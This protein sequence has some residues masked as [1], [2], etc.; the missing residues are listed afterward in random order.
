MGAMAGGAFG[1]VIH[2]L[3]P[4]ITASSGAYAL[5]GMGAVVAG[6][7]HAPIQAFLILFELTQDYL[8]IP[9]LMISCVIA[10]IVA[11][12]IKKESIY[13]LKLL[14]RG[15]DI[16]AGREVNILKNLKVKDFMT[17]KPETVKESAPLRELIT[18]LPYSQHTSFPVVDDNGD[19]VGMLSLKDFRELVFEK[20][21]LDV[22]IA[23]DIATIP[24][25]SV[26]A[27][28]NLARSLELIDNHGIE[29]LPV[30]SPS[31]GSVKVV[32]IL[33]QRDVISGY[34]QALE[35]RGLRE[36]ALGESR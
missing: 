23:R 35:A 10:T 14:R 20:D 2:G 9:P 36:I 28:D 27:E 29:R 6:A 17:A 12:L 7:T 26:S 8:I 5:V 32:G 21:L 15:I 25:I 13:T 22:V 4:G 31:T 1:C 33:S 34:N 18:V 3:F 30:T 19:L 16:Q 11:G 24:A